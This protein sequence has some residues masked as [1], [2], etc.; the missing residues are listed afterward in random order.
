MSQQDATAVTTEQKAMT[1]REYVDTCGS[2]CPHCRS[3]D[4][5]SV[6]SFE[7]DDFGA[8][9]DCECNACGREWVDSYRLVG[10]FAS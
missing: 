7:V 2:A 6:G 4:I 3:T 1:D 10:W 8:H 9:R 5:E